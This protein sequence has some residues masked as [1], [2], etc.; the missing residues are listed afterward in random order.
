MKT[1]ESLT[2]GQT[3]SDGVRYV[4]W[5]HGTDVRVLD[6]QTGT[7]ASF[8]LPRRC[9]APGA[10][11]D[12]VAASICGGTGIQLLDVTTGTW[13]PIP[14]SPAASALL[15]RGVARVAG[16]G[17]HWVSITVEPTA[18][19]RRTAPPGSSVPPANVVARDPGDRQSTRTST[20]PSCGRPSALRCSAPATRT[21]ARPAS[22]PRS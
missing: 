7:V 17:R 22:S 21:A 6:D 19:S 12:R 1:V 3:V 20:H 9:G 13:T 2:S 11:A 10:L 18:T 8:P 14:L 5:T 15:D 4:S 16:V